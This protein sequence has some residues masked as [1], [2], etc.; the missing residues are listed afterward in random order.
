[1]DAKGYPFIVV[2]EDLLL[3]VSAPKKDGTPLHA[4]NKGTPKHP[5]KVLNY[6]TESGIGRIVAHTQTHMGSSKPTET[7]FTAHLATV[8]RTMALDKRGM[9]WLPQ[10]LIHEDLARGSLVQAAPE[11]GHIPMVIKLYRDKT[12]LSKAGEDFWSANVR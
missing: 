8:L 7:V 10:S 1:M 9:A 3:P 2:G 4:L 11:T 6:S 12:T 5:T